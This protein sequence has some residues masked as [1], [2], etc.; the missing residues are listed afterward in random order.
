MTEPR[1][2][3]RLA[4]QG[5]LL[6]LVI[7]AWN[8]EHYITPTLE[9]VFE[10][11]AQL[12]SAG[13][14]AEVIVVD[15]V[16][17]DTTV[18]KA[19]AFPVR[20]VTEERRCIAAVRNRGARAACGDY[21]VFLDADSR[22]S[23]NS[24]VRIRETLSSGRYAGGGV[25]ILPERWVPGVVPLFLL[26]PVLRLVYGIS[27]GMI[28]ATREAFEAVGGFNDLLYAAEDL[29]FVRALRAFARKTGKK[30]ANLTDVN[31]RTS[32][33]KFE[34]AGWRDWLIFPKYLLNRNSV[35]RR[36]NCRLWYAEEH[37]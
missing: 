22:P 4:A 35:R 18:A 14:C 37:R 20:V 1:H 8:E 5:P 16:S 19:S 6:S 27:A 7:P 24:L 28:F 36:E 33:R 11:V 30:F 29:E 10:A 17:T 3:P 13:G 23:P 32:V 2:D 31:I 21:L 12:E 25:R 15:N 34:K 9:T 26:A